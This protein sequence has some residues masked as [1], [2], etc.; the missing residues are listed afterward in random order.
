MTLYAWY[1]FWTTDLK[2]NIHKGLKA[3]QVS[4]AAIAYCEIFKTICWDYISITLAIKSNNHCNIFVSILAQSDLK[5]VFSSCLH[6]STDNVST[7]KVLEEISTVSKSVLSFAKISVFNEKLGFNI[8]NS[9]ISYNFFPDQIIWAM[10]FKLI[11]FL[12]SHCVNDCL[13]F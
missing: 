13:S 5:I 7:S 4:K 6:W 2:Q 12:C 1:M 8:M 3:S 11:L 9:N 10:L